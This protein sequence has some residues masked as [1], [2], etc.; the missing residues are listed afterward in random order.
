M[1]IVLQAFVLIRCRKLS[2]SLQIWV[3]KYKLLPEWYRMLVKPAA[4]QCVQVEMTNARNRND[5]S[6]LG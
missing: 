5:I 6:D 4:A 3:Q 1:V 2:E